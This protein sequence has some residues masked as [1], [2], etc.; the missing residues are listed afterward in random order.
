MYTY[1]IKNYHF[2]PP[3]KN[4]RSKVL[5]NK[6]TLLKKHIKIIDRNKSLQRS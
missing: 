5:F 4:K 3:K 1:T 6:L 2:T